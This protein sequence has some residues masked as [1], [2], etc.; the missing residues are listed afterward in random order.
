MIIK[1]IKCGHEME[2]E[3]PICNGWVSNCEKCNHIQI[4]EDDNWRTMTKEEL[5][6]LWVD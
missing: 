1:C 6:E 2:H 4:L 5:K 3:Y